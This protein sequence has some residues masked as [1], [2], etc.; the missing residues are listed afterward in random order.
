MR[1]LLK[2]IWGLISC[3]KRRLVLGIVFGVLSGL[4]VPLLMI[5]IKLAVSV[6]FPS[7]YD[8]PM[9]TQIEMAP[10]FVQNLIQSVAEHLPRGEGTVSTAALLLIIAS[11][12]G[13]MIL[14]GVCT[15]INVYMIKWVGTRGVM[16]LR[17][18]LFEHFMSH[19]IR[20]H[21]SGNSGELISRVFND[22]QSIQN[23]I[24]HAVPTIVRDP[25]TVISL[26][27][28]LLYNYPTL[29]GVTLI[30]FPLCVVPI[31]IYAIKIRKATVSLQNMLASL[32]KIMQEA[33]SGIRIIKSYNLENV[34]NE[35]FRKNSREQV[36]LR[37]R[38]VRADEMPSILIEILGAI[39]AALVLIYIKLMGKI[40]MSPADF[41]A[42]IGSFFLMYQPIKSLSKIYS[43]LAQAAAASDRIY[44]MLEVKTDVPEPVHPKKLSSQDMEIVF[45]HVSFSY[46]DRMVL[47]D[48]NLTIKPGQRI[49]LVGATGSG[50]STLLHL[51]LRFYDPT[52]GRITIGGTDIREVTTHDLHEKMAIVTQ[53]TFLFDDT[54]LNNIAYGKEGASFEEIQKVAKLALAEEF[55]LQKPDGYET[56]VGERGVM[57]SGG[58]RQR[59]AIARALL[60]DAPILLLDEAT[61]A[62]DTK[63]ERIVQAAL[64][65]LLKGRTSV[66]IAHRLST[67]YD[68]DVILVLDRGR[69]VESG[70]H[71]ELLKNGG[72]YKRLYDLQ[73][74]QLD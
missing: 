43:E 8:V 6:I 57:L 5:T 56:H 19:S 13:V 71:E 50:K 63:S 58:Q 24:T 51:I 18:R 52:T 1:I 14:K 39:G 60:R 29:T 34:V 70:T 47:S 37:M 65:E 59:L 36:S 42:F 4:V 17:N 41:L 48:I 28:Y 21:T 66:S 3:Y 32:G 11:I 15:Y 20:F 44:E 53:D 72:V 61:S 49:A 73:F 69:I 68:S 74:T 31:R 12:P 55:I 2:R 33:F 35:K 67:I 7:Q 23:S 22:T 16:N 25:I 40:E 9:S 64:E 54:I 30:I 26:A 45:D 46:G 27:A 10:Q 38:Q 62:L